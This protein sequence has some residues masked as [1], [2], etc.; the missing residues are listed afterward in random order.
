[1]KRGLLKTT[2]NIRIDQDLCVGCGMCSRACPVG[3]IQGELRQPHQIIEEKCVHCGQCVQACNIP[4]RD[5]SLRA[6]KL[7]E[8]GMLE[9]ATEPLYAAYQMHQVQSVKDILG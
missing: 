8:R 5:E 1:M 9:T 7:K 2:N 3:A 6:Q 4:L